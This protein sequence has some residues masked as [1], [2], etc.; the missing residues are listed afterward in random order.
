VNTVT[1]SPTMC[2]RRIF[3]VAATGTPVVSGPALAIDR[4]VPPGIVTVSDNAAMTTD[5]IH[6]LLDRGDLRSEASEVG[7][8]WI[9]AGNTYSDRADAIIATIL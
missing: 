5:S 9:T 4:M 1:E 8:A 2:A 3:E 7:P 6:Q